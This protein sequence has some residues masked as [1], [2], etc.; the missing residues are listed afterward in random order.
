MQKY[1]YMQK[2]K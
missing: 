2:R 1:N